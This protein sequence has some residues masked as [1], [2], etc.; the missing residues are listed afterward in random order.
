MF[1]IKPI[2]KEA[3][4]ISFGGIKNGAQCIAQYQIGLYW[5]TR[6]REELENLTRAN[7]K[8]GVADKSDVPG[9]IKMACKDRSE[10]C[11]IF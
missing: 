8:L 3:I 4:K 7:R 9:I 5:E 11:N 2:G 1:E 6:S 10:N